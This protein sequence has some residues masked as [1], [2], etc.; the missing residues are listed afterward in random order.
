MGAGKRNRLV[1]LKTAVEVADGSSAL[2][3]TLTEQGQAWAEMKG[4]RGDKQMQ[5]A[6]EVSYSLVDWT[7]ALPLDITINTQTVLAYQSQ[8]YEVVEIT[9]SSNFDFVT[10]RT[11]LRKAR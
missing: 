8:E 2:Q 7:I 4:V 1:T 3:R 11:R 9:E 5:A 6:A 10:L